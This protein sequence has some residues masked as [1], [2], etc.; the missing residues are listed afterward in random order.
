MWNRKLFWN[1]HEKLEI[2][3]ILHVHVCCVKE[4]IP[5]FIFLS[6]S[7]NVSDFIR[8]PDWTR[9]VLAWCDDVRRLHK[10]RD[11]D[12]K[13]RPPWHSLVSNPSNA[14]GNV[15]SSSTRVYLIYCPWQQCVMSVNLQKQLKYI[16]HDC[17]L[18]KHK[19]IKHR[20]RQNVMSYRFTF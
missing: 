5:R 10:L 8:I 19:S 20:H 16:K 14:G 12:T 13:S 4:R 15:L 17:F 18:K 2:L 7:L 11:K 9:Q 6:Q 1:Q 3:A